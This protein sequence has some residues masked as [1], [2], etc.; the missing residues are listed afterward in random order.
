M[1]KEIQY[2][3]ILGVKFSV[4]LEEIKKVYCKLVF[5]YYL[6]KNLDEGEKVWVGVGG[7]GFVVGFLVWEFGGFELCLLVWWMLGVVGLVG[8]VEVQGVWCGQV[9]GVLLSLGLFERIEVWGFGVFVSFLQF[10]YFFVQFVSVFGVFL[11]CVDCWGGLGLECVYCLQ[12]LWVFLEER[13][14]VNWEIEVF[15]IRSCVF[16]GNDWYWMIC[17]FIFIVDVEILGMSFFNLSQY[18]G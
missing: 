2:Y 14:L 12:G 17:A 5:K 7:V 18:L 8:V 15:V 4:F 10:I 11:V 1:V 13:Q 3:D 9:E 16:V 6:D